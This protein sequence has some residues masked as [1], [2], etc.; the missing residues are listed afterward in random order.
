MTIAFRPTGPVYAMA[1]SG[2]QSAF[3]IPIEDTPSAVMI[4][5]TSA[6]AAVALVAV[7]DI[8]D[9]A[10]YGVL[11]SWPSVTNAYVGAGVTVMPGTSVVIAVNTFAIEWAQ[12]YFL[13]ASGDS[14]DDAGTLLFT[15]GSLE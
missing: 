15:S 9:T 3:T 14:P 10:F 1:V 4:T 13:T 8:P 6:N 2:A 11:A 7:S 12:G 5:N